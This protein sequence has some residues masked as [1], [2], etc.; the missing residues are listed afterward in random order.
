MSVNLPS[1]S[2][3]MGQRL[4]VGHYLTL[5]APITT[6]ADDNFCEIFPNFRKKGMIFVIFEKAAKFEIV[7][8]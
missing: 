4:V 6:E 1:Q 7:V 3:D 8:C 2:I 5:K